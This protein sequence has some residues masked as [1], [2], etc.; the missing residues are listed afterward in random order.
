MTITLCIDVGGTGLKAALVDDDAQILGEQVRLKTPYPCPPDRLVERLT[1]LVEHIGT[2]DRVSVGFP[3]LVRDG[4][5]HHV[6]ALSRKTQAGETDQALV[7]AWRGYE[8]QSTLKRA[9]GKPTKVANDAD[10]QGTAVIGG[11]GFEFVMTLGTGV[12]TA[13]FQNGALLPHIELSHAHFRRGET[14]D[15]ALGNARRKQIGDHHWQREVVKAIRA[16]D[17]FLYF[18]HCYVGGGNATRMKGIRLPE[19]CTLV[20][21][22]AGLTGGVKLWSSRGR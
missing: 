8:L 1:K 21:N 10:V 12:G 17:A 18:D 19:H 13:V 14:F 7:D 6:P 5:A 11:R 16:F 20:S 9:F 22:T 4:V 3:G 15:E 2:Y